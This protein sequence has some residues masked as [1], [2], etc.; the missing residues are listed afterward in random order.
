MLVFSRRALDGT[1]HNEYVVSVL[2]PL[3]SQGNLP[4]GVHSATWDEVTARFGGTAWRDRL[5]A[6][7][8]LALVELKRAGCRTA[9]LDGSFITTK[10]APGDFDACW[11]EVGVR[12]DLDPIFFDFDN[13]RAAQKARFGG[14]LFPATGFKEFFQQDRDGNPKGIVA[15]DLTGWTP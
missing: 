9:Y 3:D 11:D 5:L 13:K 8:R 2:P 6:G 12:P 1:E 14:E 15:I 7:F 10:A 4:P